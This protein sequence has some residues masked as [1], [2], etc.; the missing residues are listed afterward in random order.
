MK[1]YDRIWFISDDFGVRSFDQYVYSK[2]DGQ[3]KNWYIVENFE[4]SG[5]LNNRY[6]SLDENI[7]SRLRNSLVNA[8][9]EQC[10]LP[11]YIVTVLDDDVISTYFANEIYGMS[12]NMGKMVHWLMDE[13]HKIVEAQKDYLPSKAKKQ[14]FPNFIWIS[15]PTHRGFKNNSL[16]EKF[17]K[18]LE[19]IGLLHDNVA[20]LQLKKVWDPNNFSLYLECEGR[21]TTEGLRSYWEAVD[22]AVCYADTMYFKKSI[23]KKPGSSTSQKETNH[24]PAVK[25]KVV[26]PYHTEYDRYHWKKDHAQGRRHHSDFTH[27]KH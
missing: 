14:G 4:I 27:N 11:K 1:G 12:H 16:R 17:G 26:R 19:K 9:M 2:R 3:N 13:Y 5:F 22:K 23:R 15:P 18:I 25:S 8:C 6:H 10:L 24:I 20:V 7:L 21:F